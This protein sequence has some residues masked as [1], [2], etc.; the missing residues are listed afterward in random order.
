MLKGQVNRISNLKIFIAEDIDRDSIVGR[1]QGDMN[2]Y[3]VCA[4]SAALA[5]HGHDTARLKSH[6]RSLLRDV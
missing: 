5:A 2:R 6:F 4:G 1:S 3:S